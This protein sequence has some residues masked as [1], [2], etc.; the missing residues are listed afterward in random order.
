MGKDDKLRA[1]ADFDGP[2][3]DRKCTDILFTLAIIIMWITMTA[4]GIASVNQVRVRRSM[5]AFCVLHLF[6]FCFWCPLSVSA[7]NIF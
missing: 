1:P 5:L 6:I 4:V 3:K 7:W 2:V